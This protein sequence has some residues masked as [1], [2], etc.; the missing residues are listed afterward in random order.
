MQYSREGLFKWTLV[1][2]L[3]GAD[4]TLKALLKRAKAFYRNSWL[5]FI[6]ESFHSC[7][8]W[9]TTYLNLEKNFLLSAIHFSDEIRALAL[10][11]SQKLYSCSDALY[12]EPCISEC[13]LSNQ[14]LVKD[15]DIGLN[16]NI[17]L[18]IAIMH[19]I[20]RVIL[21]DYTTNGFLQKLVF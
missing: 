14:T 5:T 13:A 10:Q 4:A 2:G 11:S 18:S 7:Y 1:H 19:S 17:K 3:V 8:T 15:L 20:I 9:V 12:F 6:S 21:Y 16:L